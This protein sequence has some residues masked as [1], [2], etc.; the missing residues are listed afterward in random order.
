MTQ[1]VERLKSLL[2]PILPRAW[3]EGYHR[4]RLERERA[5]NAGQN[6]GK[7]FE[8]IYAQNRWGGTQGEFCSGS[9]SDPSYA[10]RYR[11]VVLEFLSEVGASR[12]VDLGCGDFR[13]GQLLAQP[14][15]DYTG[16]DVVGPLIARNIREYAGPG[17]RFMCLD[18]TADPLPPGDVCLIRQVLQHLSNDQVNTIL[19]QALRLY[20]YVIV[21]EHMPAPGP[22]IR[23]NVDKP[24]GPDTRIAD[25]SGLFLDAEPFNLDIQ[26]V[27]LRMDVPRPLKR[28]GEQIVTF[29]LRGNTA[30]EPMA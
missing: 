13:V 8:K 29:L 24:H 6:V 28:A 17:L 15:I 5:H 16:V 21:T 7:V 9:G 11:D 3:L 27:L 22:W 18:I 25:D 19:R 2:R 14:T 30:Q 4:F 10:L 23:H 12:V 1:F 20:Q 26:A